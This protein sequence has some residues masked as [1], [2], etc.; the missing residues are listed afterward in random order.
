V[1]RTR[2]WRS[3]GV[4][5]ARQANPPLSEPV[6][7]VPAGGGAVAVPHGAGI[8][9]WLWPRG[10]QV[11][12]GGPERWEDG[13]TATRFR[14]RDSAAGGC[15]V[16]VPRSTTGYA[17]PSGVPPARQANPPSRH[18]GRVDRLK[19]E[20]IHCTTRSAHRI[21]SSGAW[22]CGT[23]VFG[24]MGNT[25]MTPDEPGGLLQPA[26][27]FEWSQACETR[28]ILLEPLS[29]NRRDGLFQR[30]IHGSGPREF[31]PAP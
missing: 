15:V 25:P 12:L 18:P 10:P 30:P 1:S 22:R 21:R 26:Q 3:S 9:L 24:S 28:P 23:Q 8:D 27:S 19:A 11:R 7:R 13:L 2:R 17:S 29:G 14:V 4:P 20:T 31:V 16:D 6:A 5:P